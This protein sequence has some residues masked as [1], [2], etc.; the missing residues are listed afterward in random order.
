MNPTHL[1]LTDF[2]KVVVGCAPAA[3]TGTP[4]DGDYVSLKG[5]SRLTILLAVDNG[6]TVTGGTVTLKQATAVAGTN[7]KEL[8]FARVYADLD[9]A[10]GDTLTETAVTANSFVTNTTNDRNLL[11]V[12]EVNAEDLDQANNF[13][14]VRLDSTGMA[15]AVGCVLYVL[16]GSRYASPIATSAITD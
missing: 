15:N 11:Y 6:T 10:A 14:C 3:L 9:V 12:I 8:P 7:E 1:Q 13:D 16:H 5:Y 4:G 2:A